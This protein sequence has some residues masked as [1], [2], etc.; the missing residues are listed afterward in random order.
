MNIHIN[1]CMHV[2]RMLRDDSSWLAVR[3]F[4]GFER[5]PERP[6][7]ACSPGAGMD[8]NLFSIKQQMPFT[9]SVLSFASK[10]M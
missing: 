8:L 7:T 6:W 5:M 1:V 10:N 3:Q 4:L 2:L 9:Q